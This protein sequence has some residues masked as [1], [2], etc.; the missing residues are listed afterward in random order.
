MVGDFA[1]LKALV[2]QTVHDTLAVSAL[3]A[4][5]VTGAQTPLTARFHTK[6]ALVGDLDREGYARMVEGINYLVFNK[7]EVTSLGI[8]LQ[9]DGSVTFPDYGFTFRLDVEDDTDNFVDIKWSV[10]RVRP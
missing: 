1:A 7:P 2:R 5:P 10:E 6:M 9:R 3:Y 4:D 8:T